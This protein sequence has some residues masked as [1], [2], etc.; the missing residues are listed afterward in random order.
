M[1]DREKLI[2]TIDFVGTANGTM[3]PDVAAQFLAER[4]SRPDLDWR[5]PDA[6]R[7]KD[8]AGYSK[9]EIRQRFP[10]PPH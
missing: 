4:E 2:G 6:H 1:I 5:Y 8:Q 9:I 7:N 3:A 10:E